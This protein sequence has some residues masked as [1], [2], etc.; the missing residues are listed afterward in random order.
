ML[1]L[2]VALFATAAALCVQPPAPPPPSVFQFGPGDL[3]AAGGIGIRSPPTNQTFS[4]VCSAP[5][6]SLTTPGGQQCPVL[7]VGSQ[8]LSICNGTNVVNTLVVMQNNNQTII[9]TPKQVLVSTTS[10]TVAL[11]LPQN[12]DT[13]AQPRFQLLYLGGLPIYGL[14]TINTDNSVIGNLLQ[15]GQ[16]L[17][18]ATGGP[19]LAKTLTGTQNRINIQTGTNSIQIS[20]P[21]D[22]AVSSSPTFVS[23][24]LSSSQLVLGATTVQAAQTS[25]PETVTIPDPGVNGAQFILSRTVNMQSGQTIQGTLTLSGLQFNTAQNANGLAWFNGSQVLSS[26]VLTNGQLLVGSTGTGPVAASL[27]GT[28]NQV[29]VA[30]GPGTI[31]LSTPQNID[32]TASPTFAGTTLTGLTANTVL[33]SNSAKAVTSQALTN[34]QLLIGST[35]AAPVAA[36]LAGTTNQINVA[37]AAGTITLSTPQNI[38]STASPTFVGATLSGLTANTV[39]VSSAGKAIA[40]QALTNGQLLIGSTGAAPVAATLTGTA[41]QVNVATGAGTI[42]LSTPQNIGTS[43]TPTFASETLTAVS[44]QLVLGTGTTTTISASAPA[45][46]QTITIPDPG[47]AANFI[48]SRSANQAGQTIS[49]VL[50]MSGIQFDTSETANSVAWFNG[51]MALLSTALTNGQLLVGSTGAAPVAATITGTT[52]QVSVAT[53]AGSI[54]LSTPQNIDA[55]A[56]PTFASVTLTTTTGQFVLGAS[57]NQTTRGTSTGKLSPGQLISM[58]AAPVQLLPAPGAGLAYIIDTAYLSWVS[59]GGNMG[60]GGPIVIQY[61][62]TVNGAGT[63]ALNSGTA[64]TAALVTTGNKFVASVGINTGT[65]AATT[66]LVNA[67][68]FISNQ[69]GAFTGSVTPASYLTWVLDYLLVPML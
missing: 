22:I 69:S 64:S 44:N 57:G 68:I 1:Y 21:Q 5:Q 25:F 27:T 30:N 34:G 2:V 39:L 38:D 31:T 63:S 28:A 18:G 53:G 51:S 13:S 6:V 9:G 26:T 15:D 61:G 42:T 12:I 8:A 50:T 29:N 65:P 36:T 24:T 56:A 10:N 17:I 45:S 49:G 14:L 55:T 16:V 20:T 58:F 66:N 33:V 59:T 48:L 7:Q 60:G 11:S 40:S 37:N 54:T 19:A 67:G 52:N 32:S 47:G 43:S 41:N 35:G 23:A 4:Y 62:N 46:S 3:C